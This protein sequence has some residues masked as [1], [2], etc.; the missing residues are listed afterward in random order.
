LTGDFAPKEMVRVIA[1]VERGG[2]SAPKSGLVERIP[3]VG[4]AKL[5]V[6]GEKPES[7]KEMG[8]AAAHGLLQV[9]YGLGRCPG[10]AGD[11]LANEVLHAL[12]DLS[13]F[14]K[15]GPVALFGDQ[16][17]ELFDL[18]AELDRKRIG[19]QLASISD[20]FHVCSPAEVLG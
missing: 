1:S 17:V 10:E 16:L 11:A 6:F 20:G 2:S 9:E 5:R 8:L 18:I 15:L 7:D 12:C 19:L 3:A 13:L 14:E 4:L